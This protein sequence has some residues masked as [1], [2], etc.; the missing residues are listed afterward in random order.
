MHFFLLFKS[1]LPSN[2]RVFLAFSGYFFF[3]F[4]IEFADFCHHSRLYNFLTFRIECD[5]SPRYEAT[6][7]IRTGSEDPGRGTLGRTTQPD[8]GPHTWLTGAANADWHQGPQKNV[9]SAQ[10]VK[11]R[12]CARNVQINRHAWVL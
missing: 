12:K 4:F 1:S 9:K 3:F 6:G 8:L 10:K 2:Y 11:G 5:R 7:Q